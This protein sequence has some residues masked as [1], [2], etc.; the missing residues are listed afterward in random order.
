MNII[1]VTTNIDY[2]V[3]VSDPAKVTDHTTVDK[4]RAV[5]DIKQPSANSNPAKKTDPSSS[6]FNDEE[7]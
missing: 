4:D 7:E 1:S 6:S 5:K 3:F 2:P